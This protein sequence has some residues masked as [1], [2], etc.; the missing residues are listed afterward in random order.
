[1]WFQFSGFFLN[2]FVL[3][4]MHFKEQK[5]KLVVN[6]KKLYISVHLLIFNIVN[7]STDTQ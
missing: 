3:K 1:M 2:N 5:I 7:F 6:C 4:I